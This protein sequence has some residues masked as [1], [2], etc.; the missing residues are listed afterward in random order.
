MIVDLTFK[1]YR[2]VKDE[3]V[4]SLEANSSQLKTHNTFSPIPD[5]KKLKLVKSAAM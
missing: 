4:L 1:N 2:S 3:Q 5:N